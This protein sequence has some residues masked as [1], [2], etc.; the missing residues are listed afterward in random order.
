P[1]L[2]HGRE[3]D[4]AA[5]LAPVLGGLEN[6]LVSG[7]HFCLL[8][9]L[10]PFLRGEGRGERK[11]HTRTKRP[12]TRLASL[13]SPRKRGEVEE[14]DANLSFLSWPGLSRPS[15]SWLE[16]SKTWMPGPRP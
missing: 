6:V 12:L 14:K 16:K 2:D 10:S 7:K 5:F 8:F 3:R 13:A 11:P 1:G 15:T 4:A 9:S